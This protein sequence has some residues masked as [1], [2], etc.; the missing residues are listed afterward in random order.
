MNRALC[1]ALGLSAVLFSCAWSV[2]A[3][4]QDEPPTAE[5]LTEVAVER[6]IAMQEDD[7]A[8]PYEGVYR[9]RRQIPVGYRV[10]GTAIV[11]TALLYAADRGDED[12]AAAIDRGIARI[13][14]E[15]DHPLMAASDEDAYDVRVWGH[16]Y[17]LDFFCRLRETDHETH[18]IDQID[19]AI[20]ELI[21]ALQVEEVR[22]GGWNYAGKRAHAPFVTSPA[23]QA[24]LWAKSQGEEVDDE[25]FGR[26]AM[27]LQV[28][29]G[30]DGAYE[31]SGRARRPLLPGA[32][33]RSPVSDVT[34]GLLGEPVSEDELQAQ[35]DAFHEHW[36][37][38]EKRRAQTGT[39]VAPYGVAP[40]YFYYGHRYL[41]QA[42][43]MLPEDQRAAEH[44]K[45]LEKLLRTLADDGTW[46]DRV[47]ERSAN[48]GTAMS[49]LAL[50]GEDVPLPPALEE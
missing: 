47:F 45:L 31:Y 30:G 7:G 23:V 6:L 9:V 35:V 15:L 43:A 14:E 36:D 42:I 48:F 1:F 40:Y 33:A 44:E 46:N 3:S 34:L 11:C 25:L 13:L 2:P 24:L 37:E 27:A 29:R 22:G 21:A 38:L 16:I 19:A 12:A 49:V 20:V 10:G 26:A 18:A 5:Q 17:A 41:A 32:I 4:A 39:H 28:G 8:W 50:L